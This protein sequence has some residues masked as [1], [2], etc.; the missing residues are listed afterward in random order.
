VA[1]IDP[2]AKSYLV[3]DSQGK[4]RLPPL[5]SLA[6]GVDLPAAGQTNLLLEY[7]IHNLSDAD[8]INSIPAVTQSQVLL[9]QLAPAYGYDPANVTEF[10]S[11]FRNVVL[12]FLSPERLEVL[13][14]NGGL[15]AVKREVDKLQRLRVI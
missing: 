5:A 8:F 4:L 9:A 3:H 11:K 1:R 2:V 10:N 7:Q 15:Q 13:Y 14:T 6:E 12:S